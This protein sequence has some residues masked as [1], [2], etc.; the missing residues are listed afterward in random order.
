MTEHIKTNPNLDL[1]YFST[2]IEEHQLGHY[3]DPIFNGYR[4]KKLCLIHLKL[5]EIFSRN[6]VFD[7][8]V[9]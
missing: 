9:A 5:R 6:R 8:P 4:L 2:Q 7:K 1:N 3:F